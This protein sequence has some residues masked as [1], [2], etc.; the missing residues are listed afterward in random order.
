[1]E[2]RMGELRQTPTIPVGSRNPQRGSRLLLGRPP[3][4][5]TRMTEIL[6]LPPAALAASISDW[7]SAS[8]GWPIFS[9][10]ASA[11]R[12]SSAC[13]RGSSGRKP[14]TSPALC[15][16]LTRA[17]RLAPHPIPV[18]ITG[19]SGT[20]KELFARAL[21]AASGRTGPFVALDMASR[22][23]AAIGNARRTR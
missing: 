22:V 19:E 3:V 18:L 21:H 16:A 11:S 10:R 1:M 20:G 14:G 8:S 9:S 15:E 5:R 4:A 13:S 6:S 12:W 2:L 23:A 17:L 7:A